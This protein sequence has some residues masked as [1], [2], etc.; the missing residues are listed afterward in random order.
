MSVPRGYEST[1]RPAINEKRVSDGKGRKKSRSAPIARHLNEALQSVGG[2]EER[3]NTARMS[4]STRGENARLR[5]RAVERRRKFP[6][7]L[8]L[9]DLRERRIHVRVEDLDR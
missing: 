1:E 3:V 9:D 8:L 6:S 2:G 7:V 4:G 5:R